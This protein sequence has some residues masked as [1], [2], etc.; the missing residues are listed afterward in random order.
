MENSC[1]EQGPKETFLLSYSCWA[2]SFFAVVKL[3][4]RTPR[5]VSSILYDGSEA[6]KLVHWLRERKQARMTTAGVML[7][8][9][10]FPVVEYGLH[11]A[12]KHD[13]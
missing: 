13:V 7:K 12:G 9:I 11:P 1:V 3:T 6:Q 2:Y 4:R 8:V 10:S 5:N